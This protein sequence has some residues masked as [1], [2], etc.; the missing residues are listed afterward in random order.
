MSETLLTFEYKNHRGEV[1]TRRVKPIGV[2]FVR[3]P[4][5]GYQPGWFLHGRCLDK[6]AIRSFALCNIILPDNE[7]FYILEWFSYA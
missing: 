2:M 3:N 4:S 7:P 1:A 6:D 5:Y